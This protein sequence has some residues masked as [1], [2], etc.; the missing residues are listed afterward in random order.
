MTGPRMRLLGRATPVEPVGERGLV[1]IVGEGIEKTFT[2]DRTRHRAVASVDVTIGSGRSVGVIGE[3]GS[4]KS[5]LARMLAGLETADGGGLHYNGIALSSHLRSRTGRHDFRRAVQMISQDVSSSFDPL[6]TL[7]DAVRTPAQILCGLDVPAADERVDEV[8]ETLRVDPAL[9]DRRPHEV[10]GG[11]RQR[12]AIARALV[13]R[14]RVLLCDEVVSALDVSVQGSVLNLLKDYVTETGAGLF[15]VSHG[16]P[17]T[18]FLVDEL[19]VMQGGRIVER[20]PTDDVVERPEHEYT[21]FLVGAARGSA[22]IGSVA[23]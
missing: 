7:R 18:A 19:I 16:I 1:Q 5:T 8:L 6:R 10:S 4:G 22:R 17:A 11:Q 21:R 12:F 2:V 3:S 15:F 23:S 14:P 13:V 20:G 9:A